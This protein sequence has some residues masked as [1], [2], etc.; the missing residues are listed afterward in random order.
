MAVVFLAE[1]TRPIQRKV[2]IKI[3]KAWT[4]GRSSPGSKPSGRRWR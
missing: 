1:Q 2:A 3:I 4:A